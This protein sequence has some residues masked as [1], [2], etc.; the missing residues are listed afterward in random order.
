VNGFSCGRFSRH[1]PDDRLVALKLPPW[2]G[3]GK[4]ELY[5]LRRLC[6]KDGGVCAVGVGNINFDIIA[7]HRK[8]DSVLNPRGFRD[9]VDLRVRKA[10]VG[11]K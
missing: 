1:P 4:T 5:S 10:S 8:L 3:V 6:T 11:W 9:F 7:T 2:T